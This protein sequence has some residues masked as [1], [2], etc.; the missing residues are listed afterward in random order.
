MTAFCS[1]RFIVRASR[2]DTGA[3]RPLTRMSGTGVGT[4]RIFRS[5][6]SAQEQVV[7]AFIKIEAYSHK[8]SEYLSGQTEA[9]AC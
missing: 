6:F 3:S 9:A 7:L 5:S 4:I 1:S 2:P 8:D